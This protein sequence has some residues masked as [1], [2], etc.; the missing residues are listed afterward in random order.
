MLEVAKSN[1]QHIHGLKHRKYLPINNGMLFLFSPKRH[2]RF[3][4]YETYLPLDLVFLINGIVLS[5]EKDVPS[6]LELPCPSYGPE[7][8][9]DSVIELNSG[10]IEELEIKVGDKPDIRLLR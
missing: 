2:V 4:M 9:V 5:I 1:S 10:Q 8:L 7:Q 3:W 6:C